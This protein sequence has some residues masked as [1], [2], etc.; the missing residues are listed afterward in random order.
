[1][2]GWADT[3]VRDGAALCL[4]VGVR[5]CVSCQGMDVG[6][7]VLWCGQ[8]CELGSAVGWQVLW[9]G[10]C[11]LGHGLSGVGWGGR[12]GAV[13][14]VVHGCAVD[15]AG[16]GWSGALGGCAFTA[17]WEGTCACV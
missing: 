5:G 14:G 2:G 10:Q 13:A 9:C 6:W 12:T 16:E 11:G 4:G 17:T 15:C 8:C 1:M 3:A 7:E